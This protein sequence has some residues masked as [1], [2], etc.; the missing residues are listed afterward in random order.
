MGPRE[1]SMGDFPA[2]HTVMVGASV[3][4]LG[5]F[6]QC[7]SLVFSFPPGG[8]RLGW[9]GQVRS[10]SPCPTPPLHPRPSYPSTCASAASAW[11]SQKAMSMARYSAMAADSSGRACSSL[12]GNRSMRAASTACTV[13]GTC[14]SASG[15]RQAIGAT[16]APQ[17]PGLHQRPHAL[18]QEEGIAVGA[19]NQELVERGQA[20]VVAQQGLQQLVSARRGQRVEP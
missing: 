8:G 20:G 12:G 15:L 14:R 3:V 7:I 17:H 16:V 2:S 11:G 5:D 9:G 6:S 13:A 19:R 1:C 10:V 4:N 18:L